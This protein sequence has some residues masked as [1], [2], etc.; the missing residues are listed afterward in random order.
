MITADSLGLG[1]IAGTTTVSFFFCMKNLASCKSYLSL[2]KA[3]REKRIK[4][5]NS[6]NLHCRN[7]V[8]IQGQVGWTPRQK[9]I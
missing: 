6:Y 1:L 5:T 8:L 3:C 2:P 9:L 7:F 4:T